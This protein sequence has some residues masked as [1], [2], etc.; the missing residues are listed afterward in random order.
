MQMITRS[1]AVR[2]GNEVDL[3]E[4]SAYKHMVKIQTSSLEANFK[5]RAPSDD[6]GFKLLN[7]LHL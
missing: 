7:I 6:I 5:N 1:Q 3:Q 4:Q 2:L